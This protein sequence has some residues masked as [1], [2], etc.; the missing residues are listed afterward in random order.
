MNYFSLVVIELFEKNRE[1]ILKKSLQKFCTAVLCFRELPSCGHVSGLETIP[2][3]RQTGERIEAKKPGRFILVVLDP[4]LKR[5]TFCHSKFKIIYRDGKI[6]FFKYFLVNSISFGII[7]FAG[8]KI[9]DGVIAVLL[10]PLRK[11]CEIRQIEKETRKRLKK[12]MQPE[13]HKIIFCFPYEK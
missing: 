9:I 3:L 1:C 2:V 10:P 13:P 4:P 8:I 6:F 11:F 5:N 7:P 12:F